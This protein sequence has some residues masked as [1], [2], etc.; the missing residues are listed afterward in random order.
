M[1]VS[2]SMARNSARAD[3]SHTNVIAGR[4][5][6]GFR[7]AKQLFRPNFLTRL[8]DGGSVSFSDWLVIG[9]GGQSCPVCR[10]GRQVFQKP[11]GRRQFVFRNSVDQGIQGVA[12]HRSSLSLG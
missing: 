4:I 10:T 5:P 9:R 8:R 1:A 6:A 2:R 3:S 7:G 11:L 12:T